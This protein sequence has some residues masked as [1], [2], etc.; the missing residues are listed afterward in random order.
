MTGDSVYKQSHVTKRVVRDWSNINA[1]V[2]LCAVRRERESVLNI[3]IYIYIYMTTKSMEGTF[4]CYGVRLH[5]ALH[6][7]QP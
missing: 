3:Y 7:I 6:D 4:L 1:Q 2:L 5:V